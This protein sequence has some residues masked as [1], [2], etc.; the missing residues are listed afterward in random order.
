MRRA[1]GSP[2]LGILEGRGGSSMTGARW[3]RG[4]WKGSEGRIT[5]WTALLVV[6]SHLRKMMGLV[7]GSSVWNPGAQGRAESG[8]RRGGRAAVW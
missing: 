8:D 6:R 7:M 4:A 1:R 2:E 3:V 5:P